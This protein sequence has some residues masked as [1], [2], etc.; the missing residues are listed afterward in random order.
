MGLAASRELEAQLHAVN[1][2]SEPILIF[3]DPNKLKTLVAIW[4]E[5]PDKYKT[6]FTRGR[7]KRAD[8]LPKLRSGASI[9]LPPSIREE[10]QL[11]KA[12][13]ST[14]IRHTVAIQ[15]HSLPSHPV[16][17][18]YHLLIGLEKGITVHRILH[19]FLCIK[20]HKLKAAFNSKSLRGKTRADFLALV[21]K[22]GLTEN[23]KVD[24]QGNIDR[25]TKAGKRYLAIA[26]ELD[27]IGSLLL[28][29]DDVSAS[30]WEELLPSKGMEFDE[31]MKRLKDRGICKEAEKIHANDVAA[32]IETVIGGEWTAL[33]YRPQGTAAVRNENLM[34]KAPIRVPET[35]GGVISAIGDASTQTGSSRNSNPN[36]ISTLLNAADYI[37]KSTQG[38]QQLSVKISSAPIASEV[39]LDDRGRDHVIIEQAEIGS[40]GERRALESPAKEDGPPS[41]R[42]RVDTFQSHDSTLSQPSNVVTPAQE[43]AIGNSTPRDVY[44]N[45]VSQTE[46]VRIKAIETIEVHT[47]DSSIR[48][49][50]DQREI[51]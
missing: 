24:V 43:G 41:K 10:Y 22:S 30:V 39:Q 26:D 46:G 35:A 50:N 12:D 33:E 29:P 19:R 31:M 4:K 13:P 5:V 9:T 15:A 36:S 37:A 28:L 16:S 40:R 14:I 11:W 21:L 1:T 45:V 18:T 17:S 44:I 51:E 48:A 27:G 32:G 20:L 38:Q 7:S 42:S 6:N 47:L 8:R 34:S 2:A 23:Q 25:W 49:T 3:E